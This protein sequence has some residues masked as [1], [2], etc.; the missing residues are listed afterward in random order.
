MNKRILI[1]DDE[2]VQVRSPSVLGRNEFSST[3]HFLSELT[4]RLS[5]SASPG[6]ELEALQTSMMFR[7]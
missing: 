1:V 2:T 7:L 5:L 6:T 4:M 3:E